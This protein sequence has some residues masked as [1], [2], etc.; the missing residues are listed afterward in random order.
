MKNLDQRSR[1]VFVMRLRTIAGYWG[2][3]LGLLL[4]SI[5]WANIGPQWWGDRTAEPLGL[6]GVAI[7]RE[8]LSIDLR[9][10]TAV[11]P[12]EVE[13]IYHLNNSGSA[14]KLDLLFITGVT[15]VSDFEVRLDG[16]LVES[17]RVPP[18]E[19][20]SRQGELPKSWQPPD[21]LPGIDFEHSRS[22]IYRRLGDTILLSFALELPPGRSIL[23]ARYRA[24]AYGED[25]DY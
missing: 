19:L 6:K 4:P 23:S 12:V 24:R 15:G 9:Q 10:L 2:V 13:A 18:E 3:L 14:K 7:I 20:S 1:G 16:R 21:D 22:H 25:E 5:V 8:K 17:R 11:Q